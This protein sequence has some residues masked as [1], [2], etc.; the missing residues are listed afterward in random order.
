MSHRVSHREISFGVWEEGQVVH[1]CGIER[2]CERYQGVADVGGAQTCLAIPAC[3]PPERLSW[4]VNK[5]AGREEATDS[6][7]IA[8]EEGMTLMADSVGK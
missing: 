8:V 6:N 2:K 1:P 7:S 4:V 3:A 5:D